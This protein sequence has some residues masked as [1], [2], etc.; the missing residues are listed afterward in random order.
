MIKKDFSD[1]G[2]GD[3]STMVN[4]GKKYASDS[5]E[6]DDDDEDYGTMKKKAPTKVDDKTPQFVKHIR[7]SNLNDNQDVR[8][9]WIFSCFLKYF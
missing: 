9:I 4:K 2:S 6:E 3:Y 8:L 1:D 5:G 7:Q